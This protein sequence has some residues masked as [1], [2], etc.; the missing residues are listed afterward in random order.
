MRPSLPEI[1]WNEVAEWKIE[2]EEIISNP[3]LNITSNPTMGEWETATPSDQAVVEH[4]RRN[5]GCCAMEVAVQRNDGYCAIE[6]AVRRNDG[7]G[8]TR[9]L[10]RGEGRP[11]DEHDENPCRVRVREAFSLLKLDEKGDSLIHSST[12]STGQSEPIFRI[13]DIR[14]IYIRFAAA[15]KDLNI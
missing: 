1:C 2:W 8:T 10:D 11:D 3:Y 14:S 7:G 15:V 12:G 6:V 5:D 9:W 13:L 4:L